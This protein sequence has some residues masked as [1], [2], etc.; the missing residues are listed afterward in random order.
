VEG[1]GASV[2]WLQRAARQAIERG[3]AALASFRN[4][5]RNERVSTEHRDVLVLV[6]QWLAVEMDTL[7]PRAGPCVVGLDL[8]GSASMTAS[9]F[10]WPETGRLE[11][12]GWFP[13]EPEL[14]ARGQEDAVGNRY[15]Q[16]AH[17]GEL[18]T[19]GGRTVPVRAWIAQTM[20]HI[21]GCEIGAVVADRYKLSEVAE[22]LDAEGLRVPVIWRGMGW[23][24]GGEDIERFR[25]AVFDKALAV[26]PSLLLRS[27][28]SDAVCAV[29]PGGNAKLVKGRSTGRIDAIAAAVLAIAEGS[30]MAGRGSRR[31]AVPVWA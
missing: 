29:D 12:L 10:F 6:D 2:E 25:R 3:G 1:V 5:H 8:G 16:M 21:A 14:L 26:A 15:V 23:R 7:P 24:D 28:L 11:A 19:V 31:A 4:L 22:G 18:R 17:R 27:A 13:A 30:R 20:E 9:A